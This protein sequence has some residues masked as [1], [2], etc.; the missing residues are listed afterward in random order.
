MKMKTIDFGPS[1]LDRIRQ[2]TNGLQEENEAALYL[3]FR[4]SPDLLSIA[5]D[6]GFFRKINQAWQMVLGWSK[7]ELLAVPF[8]NF[9]HP[10]DIEKTK[11][12]MKRMSGQDVIRFHNRYQRKPGTVNLI[13]GEPIAGDNDYVILEWSGTAWHNGLTCAAARQVPPTCLNCSTSEDRFGWAHRRGLLY[14]T[15]KNGIIKDD[16]TKDT[17]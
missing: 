5:D 6:T 13:E 11:E 7:E 10:D 2:L 12:M 17:E 9:I 14:D 1:R 8:I 3:F 4:L 15:T 16:T